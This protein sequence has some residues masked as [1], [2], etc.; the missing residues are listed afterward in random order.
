VRVACESIKVSD[1]P[2]DKIGYTTADMVFVEATSVA[3]GFLLTSSL[4]GL[5]I[6]GLLNAV[7]ANF[8]ANYTPKLARLYTTGLL[9]ATVADHLTQLRLEFQKT[10][11]VSQS[12]GAGA[13]SDQYQSLS[14]AEDAI[15]NTPLLTGAF[16]AHAA[17]TTAFT[18][19][20][21]S[22]IADVKYQA[23]RRIVNSAA[24]TSSLS[25]VAGVSQDSVYA[26]VR[27]MGAARMAQ[28]ALE[29]SVT[30]LN[31]ALEQYDQVIAVLDD[32][33][34]VA[35]VACNDTLFLELKNFTSTV[36]TQL[37]NRA[38]KLPALVSYDFHKSVHSLVAAWEM[39]ADAR[40]FSE[41]E[42]RNPAGL[43]FLTGP[44]VIGA[45]V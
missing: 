14:D 33:A 43:P 1:N 6:S 18:L 41:I 34:N 29:T 30:T 7:Q 15:N 36:K 35:L 28:A 25:G 20:S 44:T 31:A 2:L 45:A 42:T 32:E 21:D 13:T 24:K 10:L 8:L 38:Y 3:A 12:N 39:F 17:L 9:P 11:V 40:R 19:L 4:F 26:T 23:M 5:D 37:L 22:T 27:L 16:T